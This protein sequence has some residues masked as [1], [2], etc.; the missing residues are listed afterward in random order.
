MT[1]EEKAKAYDEAL[2]RAVEFHKDTDRHLKATI[3]RIFPE[4]KESK[5]ERIRKRLID[6][7]KFSLKGAEEQ[8]AAGCSRQKDIEAYK[9]GIAYLEKHKEHKSLPLGLSVED[10]EKLP[11]FSP[12]SE[13]LPDG[14]VIHHTSGYLIK[15]KEQKPT[16][17][18]DQLKSF[19][20]RYL[21]DAANRKDD[22]EIEADTDKWAKKILEYSLGWKPSKEQIIAVEAA[23]SVLKSHDTWG[24]DEHLPIL[25]SLI[26]DLQKLL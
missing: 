12:S 21:Q 1:L 24:E 23:Y 6:C 5:D 9:W 14:T 20:L 4:L 22:S 26:N 16:I 2:E 8:D 11:Y 17:T 13:V 10:L 3:E 18:I 7:L 15:P 25:M 19:M